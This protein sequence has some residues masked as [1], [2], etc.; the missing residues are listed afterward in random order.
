VADP[1]PDVVCARLGEHAD[2]AARL[3][4]PDLVAG[5]RAVAAVL[6]ECFS[7]G[8]TLYVLGNGGSAADAAHLAAEFIGRCTRDRRPL[9][10]VALAENAAATTALA[11]DYGYD[12]V[13]ARHVTA[14]ARPGD[15][16][17]AMTTSGRS[18]NVVNALVAA[19]GVQAVTVVLC[20]A[21]PTV[22]ADLADHCLA[23]PSA[24]TGRVQETHL[25][26]GHIWA[27]VVEE[28][29]GS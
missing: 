12:E 20:G 21:D 18:A 24:T 14:L 23:V 16:V 1:Q 29:L 27:E 5:V 3:Q 17:L 25:L 9:P 26:W 13:F 8:G 6:V 19:R 7:R 2:L 10:A 22:V 28:S 15:V 4:A 11:N